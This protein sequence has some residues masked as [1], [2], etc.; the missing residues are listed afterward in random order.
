[1]KIFISQTFGLLGIFAVAMAQFQTGN[2]NNYFSNSRLFL[3]KGVV[4]NVLGL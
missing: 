2:Y 4:R 3:F 1:M